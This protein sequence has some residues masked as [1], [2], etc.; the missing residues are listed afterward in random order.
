MRFQLP[1]GMNSG[2]VIVSFTP[3]TDPHSASQIVPQTS[4]PWLRRILGATL[5]W[6]AGNSLITGGFLTYFAAELGI[7]DRR[8]ALLLALPE[9]IGGLSI[10]TRPLDW[11]FQ[12]RKRTW[13]VASLLAR[14]ASLAIPVFFLLESSG[15]VS[16][17]S[18]LGILIPLGIAS[19]LQAIANVAWLSWMSE[20]CPRPIW[21]RFLALRNIALLVT[22]L[23]VPLAAGYLRD[24]LRTLSDPALLQ[25]FYL[26]AFF[27]GNLLMLVSLLP[28]IHV[29]S[30]SSLWTTASL[31]SFSL[32]RDIFRTP[33][34]RSVI[35]FQW[36]HAF[37]SGLT[38]A[39]F[40]DYR[41]HYLHVGLG[42]FYL[43]EG[44][45]R[46]LQI[47]VSHWAGHA[48]DHGQT[49]PALAL[50]IIALAASMIFWILATPLAW[51][52]LWPAYLLWAAWAAINVAGPTLTLQHAPEGDNTLHLAIAERGAGMCAGI[53]GLLG[54][55]LLSFFVSPSDFVRWPYLLLFTLGLIG[56]LASLYWL[57][58]IDQPTERS[59]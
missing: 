3:V 2:A 29:P 52:W 21:G 56:R 1:G 45:M 32:L 42:T 55:S 15:T 8:M 31:P 38:Q 44:T 20:I 11:G 35:W 17:F 12:N 48:C 41:F 4:F 59:R 47:P 36:S 28:Y 22:L 37:W 26:T 43:L 23:T 39:P 13:L 19:L 33:H 34:F 9:L 10:L 40:F 7:R 54:G 49:R 25:N 46:L 6:T 51:W 57:A 50:G 24:Y 27:S 53:A 58:R 14:L 18:D 30:P 16:S 5:L